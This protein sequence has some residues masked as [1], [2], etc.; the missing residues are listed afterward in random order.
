MVRSHELHSLSG[1]HTLMLDCQPY[2]NI[3]D[4]LHKFDVS[5]K[6]GSIICKIMNTIEKWFISVGYNGRMIDIFHLKILRNNI[7]NKQ[8]F[9]PVGVTEYRLVDENLSEK[10][11]K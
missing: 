5:Y 9:S 8:A 7:Y 4:T 10:N 3:F 11:E 6:I 1:A 2:A